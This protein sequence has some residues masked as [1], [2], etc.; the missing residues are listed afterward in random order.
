[1]SR[2][3]FRV[4]ARIFS[5]FSQ[6]EPRNISRFFTCAQFFSFKWGHTVDSIIDGS[7]GRDKLPTSKV[8]IL[9]NVKIYLK[10]STVLDIILEMFLAIAIK[11][12][13]ENFR[14]IPLRPCGTSRYSTEIAEAFIT[15]YT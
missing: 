13:L 8:R 11:V 12:N 15:V 3:V 4:T 9:P 6:H 2:F 14:D 1:M 5:R 10:T 7:V